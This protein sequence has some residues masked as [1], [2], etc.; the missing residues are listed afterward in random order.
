MYVTP[1]TLTLTLTITL[2]LTLT[3]FAVEDVYRAIWGAI[4]DDAVK[5]T[6]SNPDPNSGVSTTPNSNSNS[7]QRRPLEAT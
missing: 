2:T 5:A 4:T 1:L 3:V 6:G 7:N